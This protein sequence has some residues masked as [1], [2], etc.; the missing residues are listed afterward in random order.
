MENS[1]LRVLV[2][3][4]LNPPLNPLLVIDGAGLEKARSFLARKA[5]EGGKPELGFDYETN[6]VKHFYDRR[7]RTLQIGDKNEQ[8]V[9]DFLAFADGNE[10][11]L[12]G[13]QGN[14]SPASYF[15]P[16]IDVVR[17]HLESNTILKVGQN[18]S[19]EY[20]V[21]KWC[22]GFRTWHLYDT[23][24]AE[25]IIWA[26]IKNFKMA[27][28]WALDDMVARY[29]KF[30]IDKSFQ[31]SFDLCTPLTEDQIAYAALDTRLPLA[32]RAMQVKVLH[33]DKLSMTALIENDSIGA[34]NDIHLNGMRTSE[35]QWMKIVTR[36]Y[37]EHAANIKRLDTFFISVV[38]RKGI[39]NVDL[40][41]LENA[42]RDLG[43]PSGEEKAAKGEQKAVLKEERCKARDAA[44][45]A[46][47]AARKSVSEATKNLPDCEG[48]ANINYNSNP[49]LRAAMLQM[50]GF[51]QTNLTDTNDDTLKKLAGKPVVDALR[52]YRKTQKSLSTYGSAWVR[53]YTTSP[54]VEEGWVHPITN[55]IHPRVNQLEAETGRTSAT[56]PN[57]QNLPKED[58]VRACFVADPPDEDIRITACCQDVAFYSF[59]ES[60]GNSWACS[61]CLNEVN[62]CDTKPEEYCIVTADM[63]G[64]ELRII[65]DYSGAKTWIDAFNNGW[66]V[67]SVSTEILYPDKWPGDALPGCAYFTKDHKKCKCPLHKEL[68]DDTKST[69]FLLCYGGGARTL[70]EEIG[71]SE[72]YASS[73]LDI[74]RAKFP[75]V[76]AWLDNMGK[77][78][79]LLMEA[80][81]MYGRRRK[82]E[83]PNWERATASAKERLKKRKQNREP[84]TREISS[85]LKGLYSS[86]ERQGKNHPIQGTN[87]DIIKRAMGCG[88]DKD[89]KP[90]L[91]HILEPKFKAKLINMVHDE[92]VVQCPK[93]FGQQVLE[94]IGD[95]YRRAAAEVMKKVKMD[96]EGHIDERWRK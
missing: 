93:R 39:P 2:P 43:V 54:G 9:F 65:A 25:K 88:F 28:F 32:V 10:N 19:F 57:S 69:N 63:S 31:K 75:D 33:Q 73:L 24:L 68:R 86:I 38:G 14:Y 34:F 49:Q 61:N 71:K 27:G 23:M 90:Y 87:A 21:G 44:R 50:K 60:L 59:S 77:Q 46:F 83:R 22:M 85:A 30:Q 35:E 80:R 51:N 41:V 84:N 74:H 8:Y 94:A 18:L 62:F 45:A 79:A 58:E 76:H 7:I 70:S 17:P 82:F 40:Q 78:A 95:A 16:I 55:R 53:K 42:W 48:E 4:E 15:N 26:G 56:N 11:K 12:I 3:S 37:D 64:A 5:N 36:K 91:W 92:L 96:Y 67:H 66:D 89:G 1:E 29:F 81:T 6:V 47:Y 72:E 13:G 20:E 52:E